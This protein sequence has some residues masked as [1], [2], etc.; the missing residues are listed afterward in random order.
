MTLGNKIQ[1]VKERP[2]VT[3]TSLSFSFQ[4]RKMGITVSYFQGCGKANSMEK[5]YVNTGT[6]DNQKMMDH[7]I[8]LSVIERFWSMVLLGISKRPSTM[9]NT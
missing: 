5:V 7:C 9:S 2:Q 8:P 4:T 6:K 1:Y 3:K